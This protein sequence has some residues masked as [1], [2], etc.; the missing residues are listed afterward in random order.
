M[1]KLNLLFTALLLL[2]CVGAAKAE[3]VTINDIKY[4][5]VNKG[6]IAT[7]IG[8]SGQR[9]HEMNHITIEDIVI[10]ETIEY[11]EITYRV[12]SIGDCAFYGIFFWETKLNKITI[13][14]SVTSI[15]ASAFS[16]CSSLTSVVIGNSV[17]SIGDYAFN[18]CYALTSIEI[19]NSVTS[20]GAS[21][22]SGCTALKSVVIGNSVTSIGD[23]AFNKCY[24]LTSIEIPNSVTSIGEGAFGSYNKL[25][26]VI[27]YSYLTFSKGSR[28]NGYIAYCANKVINA[29]NGFKQDD[30]IWFENEGTMTL[31]GYLGDSAELTLP[32]EYNGKSVTGIGNSAFYG[33]TG[34]TSITIPNS[35]TSI[36][37]SAFYGC[38]ELTNVTIPNS[39]TSI[40]SSTFYDCVSLT[41]ITIP[42][43]VTSIGNKAFAGCKGL[44]SIAIPNS[45][46]SIGTFAFGCC[47]GLTSIIIPNRV[48]SI[49]AEA[50][51]ECIGLT[52]VTI[53]NSVTSIGGN[54]F[55][56]CTGLTNVTLP[57]NN[58]FISIKES[59]FTG[60]SNL[61]EITIP[62]SVVY[63]EHYA[64]RG[65]KNIKRVRIGENVTSISS[66]A[67]AK[68]DNLT[69]VYCFATSVPST[70]A[71][72]F[73]ES[74]P[75]Y[76]TLHVPAE[77]INSYRTAAPWNTFGTIVTLNGEDIEP[78]IP[79][80]KVC[81]T[82]VISYCDGNLHF[83]CETEGAE[84]ITDVTCSDN[85]KFYD[86]DINFSATYNI[87]VYAMATGYEN[88]ETV[89]AT[90]CWI[91]CECDGSDDTGVI[92]IP[93]TAALVTSNGGV[94]SISCQLDGEEVAVYT[95]DGVIVGT[96]TIDNGT[97]TIATG[98]SKGTVAIVKIADKSIKVIIG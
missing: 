18:E 65:C 1:K 22:F 24:A 67:F 64:F 73:E 23:Y 81:A 62:N 56:G 27:N 42:N 94:L 87:S 45:V 13:P 61:E 43:S 49:E 8:Y 48:T 38:H 2:C 37:S 54:A 19:P 91:E 82:P 40:K 93:A 21:A 83:E 46:T 53:G 69:D 10:P 95:T 60:C 36:G 12:T 32:A 63:I 80:V 15:G 96:A 29:P 26:T 6:K 14:N 3:E 28:N 9:G 74:Y 72:A 71:S 44:K 34:L 39:V 92:N 98:L 89:N 55:Y 17:R 16:G 66:E 41:S 57:N 90:L 33:C 31:A 4:D 58:S 75:E 50:F 11:N 35:V 52:S 76:M 79:E 59:C 84:F 5:V 88:S 51:Y 77:A 7:V 47:F 20:I 30:Y 68:C 86:S 97:A 25:K 78:E 85:K 70:Y